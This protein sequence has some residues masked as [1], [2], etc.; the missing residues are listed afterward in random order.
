M[1]LGVLILPTVQSMPTS[2]Y[3][4]RIGFY[5]KI[6]TNILANPTNH[7]RSN[8]LGLTSRALPCTT[9][10]KKQFRYRKHIKRERQRQNGAAAT[11]N[12]NVHI[13]RR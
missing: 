2:D 9:T 10:S 4:Y 7:E 13:G 6:L 5:F 8:Q 1:Q 12:I 3:R 11:I